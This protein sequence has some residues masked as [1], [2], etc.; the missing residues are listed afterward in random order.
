MTTAFNAL[1]PFIQAGYKHRSRAA[2]RVYLLENYELV[3]TILWQIRSGT[4]EIFPFLSDSVLR[5]SR[6]T[7]SAPTA[8]EIR[9]IETYRKL[10]A[11]WVVLIDATI[12]AL[13]QVYISAGAS[14][15]VSSA[16]AGLGEIA[17]DLSAA[18]D[19]ARKHLAELGAL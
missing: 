11:D 3:R 17:I 14:Q 19:A 6:L 13:D 7:G 16:I 4:S 2:L 5:R 10:L 15:T 9:K 1:Q 18:S 8:E 12:Q